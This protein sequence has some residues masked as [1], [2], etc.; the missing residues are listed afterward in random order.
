MQFTDF[1]AKS[2]VL[3]LSKSSFGGTFE[4]LAGTLS[5]AQVNLNPH[6]TEA[7]LFAFKSPFGRG[8]IIGD[9]TGLGKTISSSIVAAQK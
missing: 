2:I 5:D 1:H 9:E 3:T 6:Q 8:I 7:A 4:K